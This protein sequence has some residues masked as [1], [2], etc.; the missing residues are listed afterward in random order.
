M[1][2]ADF[3]YNTFFYPQFPS[4][5]N[6]ECKV[7][8]YWSHKNLLK[9]V[10]ILPRPFGNV[11]LQQ[12]FSAQQKCLKNILL[13]KV[14][15]LDRIQNFFRYSNKYSIIYFNMYIKCQFPQRN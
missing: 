4:S 14:Y 13:K 1:N 11:L 7:H 10:A 12:K 5:L 6:S 2:L 8:Y 15:P 3:V 9:L